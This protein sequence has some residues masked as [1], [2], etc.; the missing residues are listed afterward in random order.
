MTD[1]QT[2]DEEIVEIHKID[3]VYDDAIARIEA[4]SEQREEE[5]ERKARLEA[6]QFSRD[7]IMDD[8]KAIDSIDEEI[9]RVKNA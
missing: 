8:E 9:W 5:I 3:A 7:T 1:T 4:R 6:L 2:P